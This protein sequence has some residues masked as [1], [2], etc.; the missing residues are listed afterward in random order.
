MLTPIDY[1]MLAPIQQCPP[2]TPILWLRHIAKTLN[3]TS[4]FLLAQEFE[5]DPPRSF[6]TQSDWECGAKAIRFQKVH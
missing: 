3:A 1:I 5:N 2:A 6:L 4:N